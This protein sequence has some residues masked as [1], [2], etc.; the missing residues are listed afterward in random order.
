MEIKQ[1]YPLAKQA[2]NEISLLQKGK[3]KLIKTGR[4]YIDETLNGVI[5][6]DIISIIAPPS[7][8]K[9][10]ELQVLKNNILDVNINPDAKD[11][12]WLDMSLEMK[13]FNIMLRV[14][15]NLIDG[16]SKKEILSQE[17]TEKEIDVVKEYLEGLKDG[18]QFIV[19]KPSSPAEFF[20]GAKQFL[21]E[22][23]DKKAVFITI[24]HM[25]LLSGGNKKE[26]VDNTVT[27][28]NELKLSYKNLYVI[29]LSQ[30]NRNYLSRIDERNRR[31]QPETGDIYQS[32]SILQ[33]SNYVCFLMNPYKLGINQYSSVNRKHYEYLSDFFGEEN[34]KTGKVSF[35]TK[36]NMFY[37]VLKIREGG[38]VYDDLYIE[39]VDIGSKYMSE[40]DNETTFGTKSGNTVPNMYD[41][42]SDSSDNDEIPF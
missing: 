11:F 34:K 14:V 4:K 25:T 3:L 16:K 29:L 9:T 8:G 30:A 19:E 12:V 37:H 23:K 13:V 2:L 38:V 21:E 27:Y 28:I 15:D 41:F 18:R 26:V 24:D 33:I 6:G 40:D 39:K 31:S 7:H 1:L 32:E 35:N 20:E 36:G 10:Y 17:F 22:H 5:P 42:D